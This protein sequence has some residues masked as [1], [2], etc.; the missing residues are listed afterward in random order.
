M[1]SHPWRLATLIVLIAAVFGAAALALA[2]LFKEE[3]PGAWRGIFGVLGLLAVAVGTVWLSDR[4][5]KGALRRNATQVDAL[6]WRTG[7]ASYWAG[8]QSEP[9]DTPGTATR[10]G[11]VCGKWRG[12]PA[13]SIYYEAAYDDE[14]MKTAH[15]V[16]LVV[17]DARLP[18]LAIAPR[19]GK[20]HLTR[21][22]DVAVESAEFNRRFV[23]SAA[24]RPFAH[25]VLHPQMME[26]LLKRDAR[27]LS[28]TFE[29][30]VV[31]TSRSTAF[32]TMRGFEKRIEV[33]A[34]IADLVPAHVKS[35]YGTSQAKATDAAATTGAGVGVRSARST[36]KNWIAPAALVV[37]WTGVGAPIAIAMAKSSLRAYRLGQST[38]G[39]L[40]RKVRFW[41][42][43]TL[44]LW[45]FGVIVVLSDLAS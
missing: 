42:Y 5:S 43:C 12:Y 40:A 38:N 27:R 35:Q 19:R 44:P 37:L 11:S 9:F 4:R 3:G 29:R 36:R 22:D 8:L 34:D 33:L 31:M 20:M 23:V 14:S 41:G 39:A 18:G 7:S 30:N 15:R 28:I 26:R 17:I 21:S 10:D 6:G 2:E 13:E 1:K 25:A 16:D 32:K 45:V 24:E